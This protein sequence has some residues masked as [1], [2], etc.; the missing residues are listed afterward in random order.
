M[1]TYNL[2]SIVNEN[3]TSILDF[4]QNTNTSLMSGWLGV[5]IL[6]IAG[7][8][9]FIAFVSATNHTGKSLA[10]ASFICFIL[11]L[12]LRVISLVPDLAIFVTGIMMAGSIAFLYKTQ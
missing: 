6:L 5:A 9:G 3:T 11:C 2:T 10:S 12:F 4:I 7:I 8:L 1:S